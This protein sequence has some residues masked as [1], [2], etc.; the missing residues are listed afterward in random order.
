MRGTGV[1]GRGSYWNEPD[2]RPAGRPLVH[3]AGTSAKP[4]SGLF[5]QALSKC[6]AW[7]F[8][9]AH[10]FGL[11]EI[12][13]AIA[14]PKPLGE[15]VFNGGE[16]DSYPSAH[17]CFSPVATPA[18]ACVTLFS[19]GEGGGGHPPR[20]LF[21]RCSAQQRAQQVPLYDGIP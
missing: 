6:T 15:S 4:L 8:W 3:R 20:L 19:F 10:W 11:L 1:I 7:D 21:D 18:L 17:C 16:W 9:G 2:S 13:C 5:S 14:C 12:S